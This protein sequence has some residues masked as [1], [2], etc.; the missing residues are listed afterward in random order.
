[1]AAA[2]GLALS[3]AFAQP[4][5]GLLRDHDRWAV[6][7]DSI[8][9][10]GR[11]HHYVGLYYLTRFP[12]RPVEWFNDGLSGDTAAGALRRFAW[13]IAPLRPTVATVMFGMNDVGRGLYGDD[14]PADFARQRRERIEAY[15]RNQRTLVARLQQLGATVILLTPSIFDQTAA[16]PVA[17]STGVDEA[18]AECAGL[19]R[20]I[21]RETGCACVDFHGPMH[22]ITLRYQRTDPGFT[23]VGPDRIHPGA[24]GHLVMAYLLLKAQGAPRE[25]AALAIDAAGRRVTRAVNG[26]ADELRWE[27]D[28]L[29]F[30]WT[31]NALPFPVEP[32][33]AAALGWIPFTAELNQETLCVTGLR[34]GSYALEIDGEKVRSCPAGELAAGINLAG[35]TATP[36]YRQ[37]VAVERLLAQRTQLYADDLRGIALLEHQAGP[38]VGHPATLA[39]MRPYVRQRLDEFRQKPPFPFTRQVV[40]GY[41]DR[42]AHESELLAQAD[43]LWQEACAAAV[44]RPHRFALVRLGPPA[45]P[46]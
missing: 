27:G 28:R 34:S 26:R 33:A 10:T 20:A 31:E 6:V 46:P 30:T 29:A 37:A 14:R 25:V 22:E 44:P 45:A 13:D 4:P 40:E 21:A 15:A 3:G 36:Q 17:K 7:G 12:G 39:E 41:A 42:K 18:L 9:Q 11:Y 35:E 23:L 5:P 19:V 1:M 24:P 32:A 38:A 43:R 2:A 8:T 16:L